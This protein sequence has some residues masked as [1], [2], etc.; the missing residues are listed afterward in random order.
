[1]SMEEIIELLKE[2]NNLLR[3]VIVE[4]KHQKEPIELTIDSKTLTEKLDTIDQTK[5]SQV[6]HRLSG[7]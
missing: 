4:V 5:I 7:L 3:Q 1:M 6:K 2:Q